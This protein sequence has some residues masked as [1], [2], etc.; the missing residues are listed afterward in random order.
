MVLDHQGRRL[1]GPF[2][3][4]EARAWVTFNYH[5]NP[6]P[7]AIGCMNPAWEPLRTYGSPGALP[8]GVWE[9]QKAGDVIVVQMP[10]GKVALFF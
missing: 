6:R 2:T 5:R 7:Y 8:R 3:E 1:A 4:R 10:D 9:L